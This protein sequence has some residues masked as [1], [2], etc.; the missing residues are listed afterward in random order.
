MQ[1][2]IMLSDMALAKQVHFQQR[3]EL[4][5]GNFRVT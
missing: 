1:F 5:E 3:A 4:Q 2:F